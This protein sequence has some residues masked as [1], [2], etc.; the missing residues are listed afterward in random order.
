MALG[1]RRGD[2]DIVLEIERAKVGYLG[3]FP[4]PVDEDRRR[5]NGLGDNEG[6][7]LNRVVPDGPSDLAGL[8]EGDILVRISGRPVGM[9]NLRQR[10][11]QI[12][13]GETVD[14]MI[15]RDGQRLT[16]PLT[17]GERPQRR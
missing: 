11:M 5:A 2:E 12:G 3:V 6:L 14:V 1:L 13:A 4:G 7:R 8:Q 16:L 9:M 15:I 10:L 17:L